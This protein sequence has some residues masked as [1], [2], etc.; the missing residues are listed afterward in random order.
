MDP[1]V[2][3]LGFPRP[4]TVDTCS[5]LKA[6]NLKTRVLVLGTSDR[7]DELVA[8]V[9]AG[10][11]GY[12]SS[13]SALTDVVSAIRRLA[14]GEAWIPPSMLGALLGNLIRRRRTENAAAEKLGRLSRRERDVLAALT[15]GLEAQAIADRLFVS[16]HTVRTHVQRV[17]QK[18][19][20]HS[21]LEAV[22]LMLDSDQ[23]DGKDP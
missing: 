2:T 1:D 6:S 16:P 20:V 3:V 11:D 17:L 18:L 7:P 8:A 12:V 22:A 23:F 10:A 13:E 9:E 5:E 4:V 21:R 14:I 15:E 19:E